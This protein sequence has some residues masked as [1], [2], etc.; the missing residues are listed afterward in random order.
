MTPDGTPPTTAGRVPWGRF[1]LGVCLA[2]ALLAGIAEVYLRLF[3]PG[4]PHPYLG[5]A[6]PLTGIY[7]ADDDFSVSYASWEALCADNAERLRVYLPFESHADGRP[8]WAFF[9]NSFVQ[10]PGM[11]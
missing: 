8:L 1:L 11:L 10:A 6:S 9:G 3:A 4:D 2:V 5:D 7:R